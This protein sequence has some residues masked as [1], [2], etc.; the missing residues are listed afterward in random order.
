MRVVRIGSIES[1]GV[2]V[3]QLLHMFDVCLKIFI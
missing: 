2:A 3:D 1:N